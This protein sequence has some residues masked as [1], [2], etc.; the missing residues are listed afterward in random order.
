MSTRAMGSK[1]HLMRVSVEKAPGPRSAGED[2]CPGCPGPMGQDDAPLAAGTFDPKGTFSCPGPFPGTW[3][4]LPV[5]GRLH[6]WELRSPHDIIVLSQS[7]SRAAPVV[8]CCE[9]RVV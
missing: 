7:P 1:A 6:L 5:L 9:E 4:L 8:P 3:Q 2:P